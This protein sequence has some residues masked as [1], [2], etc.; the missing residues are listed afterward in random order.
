MCA[1]AI[2]Q[3][4]STQPADRPDTVADLLTV[5]I[6]EIR[7]LRRDLAARDRPDAGAE[8]LSI[9]DLAHQLGIS[10]PTLHRQ[11]A[12]GKILRATCRV[13]RSP[14]WSRLDVEK[15]I[16]AGTPPAKEWTARQ[17]IAQ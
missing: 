11:L 16:A 8:L 2:H 13:G 9:E 7:G 14:R 17:E 5:L 10:K 4:A 1:L 6:A 3:P 15:W 12:A